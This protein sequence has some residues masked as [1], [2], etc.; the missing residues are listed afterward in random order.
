MTTNIATTTTSQPR[1]ENVLKLRDGRLLGFA[2]YGDPAGRPIYAFHGFPG[3]RLQGLLAHEAARRCGVR[4]ICP[5]RPGMGISSFK[6]GRRILDWPD[7]LWELAQWLNTPR[8]AVMGTSGGAPYALACAYR[9]VEKLRAVGV[10]SGVAPMNRAGA[11]ESMLRMNRIIF[12]TQ[13]AAPPVGRAISWMMGQ[14]IRRLGDRMGDAMLRTLPPAD[15]AVL[16]RPEVRRIFLQDAQESF[17]H[18]ARGAAL[19]NSLLVRPWGFRL[20]N[21]R[22]EVHLWQGEQDRN[23]PP[24]HGRY[25]ATAIPNCKAVFYS[26]EGH[27][28]GV[29][30]TDAILE[31]LT[32]GAE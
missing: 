17:R 10:V 14:S 15:R 26:D 27:L 13:Q 18:G 25:M 29:N 6:A 9:M 3:S 21:I 32:G 11:T 12:R 22:P 30:H 19:E 4:L 2:E 1:T 28:L 24:S 20:E 7:D 8:F 16:S 5:D 31:A 23:V